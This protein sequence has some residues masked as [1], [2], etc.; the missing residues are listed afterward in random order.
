MRECHW[1]PL[2][3]ASQPNPNRQQV[4]VIKRREGPINSL[5]WFKACTTAIFG[6]VLQPLASPIISLT[7]FINIKIFLDVNH[8]G[9]AELLRFKVCFLI[10]TGLSSQKSYWR[11]LILDSV[12][13]LQLPRKNRRSSWMSLRASK[14][15]RTLMCFKE[16]RTMDDRVKCKSIRHLSRIE[17]PEA[18]VLMHL[19]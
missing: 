3:G 11:S 18:V 6:T 17:Q 7:S 12:E 1:V 2:A 19:L 15:L 5:T 13:H 4:G 8:E 16:I 10:F 9:V 14:L